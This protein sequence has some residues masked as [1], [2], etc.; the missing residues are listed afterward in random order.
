MTLHIDYLRMFVF[1]V[2][3]KPLF[4]TT[5]ELVSLHSMVN[6]NNVTFSQRF[7]TNEATSEN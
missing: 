1:Q 6:N 2:F 4:V 7:T 5:P 3:K